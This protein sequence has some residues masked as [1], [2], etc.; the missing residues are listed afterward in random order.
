MCNQSWSENMYKIIIRVALA[1]FLI[2]CFHGQAFAEEDTFGLNEVLVYQDILGGPYVDDW[3]VDGD[4]SHSKNLKV[5]REGKS[6][7]LE[8]TIQIDCKFETLTILGVGLLYTSEILTREEV[9]KYL[10]KK[11]SEAIVNKICSYKPNT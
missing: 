11:I 9:Q 10:T 1:T 8:T 2:N 3:Y 7:S 5:Y 6:G 4:L